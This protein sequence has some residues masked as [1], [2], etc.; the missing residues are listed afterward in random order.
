LVDYETPPPIGLDSALRRVQRFHEA[1]DHP[2]AWLPAPLPA[3]RAAR[4][5]VWM[6]EEIDEFEAATMLVDQTDAM[7]DLIYFALGTLVELGV[8]AEAVFDVVHQANMS[9]K[10]RTGAGVFGADGKVEKPPGWVSPEQRIRDVLVAAHTG[11]R[12]VPAGDAGPRAAALEMVAAALG[13]EA[14]AVAEDFT[15]ADVIEPGQESETL[16]ALIGKY[17]HVGAGAQMSTVYRDLAPRD[18]FVLVAAV[19]PVGRA[20]I[21]DPEPT[22]GG[23]HT[24]PVEDLFEGIRRAAD[25]LHAFR[26][27]R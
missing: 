17:G 15:S 18:G 8:P 4:R 16:R 11:Y 3:T 9:K 24:V 27:S 13:V 21:V 26:R 25:G 7:I 12:F 10:P 6:R 14:D 22:T 23:L 19:D 20:L 2:V 1:F 5:A